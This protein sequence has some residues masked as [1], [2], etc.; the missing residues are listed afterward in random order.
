MNK[1]YFMYIKSV[2]FPMYNVQT[3]SY[4]YIICVLIYIFLKK[5]NGYYLTSYHN[6]N[7]KKEYIDI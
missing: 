3:Y 1:M 2:F 4:M 7:N 6:C 5:Y